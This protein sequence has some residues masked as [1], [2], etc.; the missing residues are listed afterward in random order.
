MSVYVKLAIFFEDDSSM[1]DDIRDTLFTDICKL[2]RDFSDLPVDSQF[3][4][5]MSD[6]L[7]F[8]FVSK[9]MYNLYVKQTA[10]C[11]VPIIY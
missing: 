2:Q 9:A 1:Y 11:D 4:L 3:I 5:I 8:K 10:V 7:Y 6:L